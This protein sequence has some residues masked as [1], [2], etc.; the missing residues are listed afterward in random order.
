[1]PTIE[2]AHDD[3]TTGENIL[4]DVSGEIREY[5]PEKSRG[6][7]RR[8]DPLYSHYILPRSSDLVTLSRD[9]GIPSW[10][11]ASDF[12]VSFSLLFPFPSRGGIARSCGPRSRR[13]GIRP[14][15]VATTLSALIEQ[16]EVYGAEY[17]C[18]CTYIY[19]H[20]HI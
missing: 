9:I 2:R 17:M 3:N 8:N 11:L 6:L 12:S 18:T 13:N 14:S 20:I 10:K 19:D 1:M 5:S 16:S 4:G 15:F 7:K